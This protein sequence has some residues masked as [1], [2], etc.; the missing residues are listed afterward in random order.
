MTEQPSVQAMDVPDLREL[1]HVLTRAQVEILNKELNPVFPY[2]RVSDVE[3][4]L[5]SCKKQQAEVK[6][7]RAENRGLRHA[8]AKWATS[9]LATGLHRSCTCP[10]CDD[11]MSLGLRL[12]EFAKAGGE[13]E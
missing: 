7:L 8:I 6:L 10:F 2:V 3:R 13:C 4:L 5:E 9:V 1:V 11:L 12:D